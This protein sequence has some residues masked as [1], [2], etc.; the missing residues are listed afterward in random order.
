MTNIT[1][2]VH[3]MLDH[4][5]AIRKDLA[6]KVINKRA[7]AAYVQEHLRIKTDVN[8]IISAIRRY[9]AESKGDEGLFAGAAGLIK[10]AK[11]STK[12]N[13]AIIGLSKDPD[14]QEILPRLF[15][16]ISYGR[17]EVIRIIQADES[18]KVIVDEKN[19]AKVTG[20]VKKSSLLK[21][22]KNVGELNMRLTRFSAKVP[23]VL[24]IL[25]TELANNNISIM[26]TC[27]CV[28]EV[29]W[30]FEQKDLLKAHQTFMELIESLK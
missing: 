26:E 24:A 19:V 12:T 5:A 13:I 8:A 23:G 7:L 1:R 20:M 4:D 25:D 18:I 10:N 29:L 6:R 11:I 2:A 16:V 30:F 28:P 22:T 21:V 3:R 14:V 27:S 17:G 15:S 9:E